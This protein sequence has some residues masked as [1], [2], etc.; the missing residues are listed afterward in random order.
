MVVQCNHQ[1]TTVVTDSEI[2][3][4]KAARQRSQEV[5]RSPAWKRPPLLL[6]SLR[7]KG[8]AARTDQVAWAART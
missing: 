1:V 2:R 8:P 4:E 7:V 6:L 3:K 5:I